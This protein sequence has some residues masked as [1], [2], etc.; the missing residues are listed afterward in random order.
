MPCE[1][2][3]VG[4]VGCGR[5]GR[6]HART[7]AAMPGVRL[8]GVCDP[9]ETARAQ[10]AA[11]FGCEAFERPEALVGR[12]DAVSVAS[13]TSRRVEAVGPL[14][15]AGVA[16]LIEKPL[17]ATVE[18]CRRIGEMA[19]SGGAVVQV[20]H[21]ERFNSAVMA[22]MALGLSPRFVEAVRLSPLPFRSLDVGVVMDVMIHDIDIV[23]SLVGVPAGRVDAI[24][25]AVVG[26]SEDLCSARVEFEG[27]AAAMFNA[28][29]LSHRVERRL[30]IYAPDAFVTV[31]YHKRTAQ[32]VRRSP[33]V[34]A[35]RAAVAEVRAGRADPSS[36]DFAR[37]A[38]L[39]DLPVDGSADA[40][41][42]QAE[43]FTRAV[44][45]QTPPAV[46]ID[47]ATRAVE[48]ATRISAAARKR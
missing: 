20:G 47:D 39:E 5:M 2:L 33:A 22:A 18:E 17:A 15:A 35:L 25:A 3:R 44:R 23:L 42:L 43:S 38:P 19:R 41:R 40:L 13:T 34:E 30:R 21:I 12:V 7:W 26:D 10:V 48:L 31:D 9:I 36:F 24:G 11:Q 4:V 1:S 37:L 29:R 6:L 16:C 28:S 32:V 45:R 14:L 27:G 8:V 46:G